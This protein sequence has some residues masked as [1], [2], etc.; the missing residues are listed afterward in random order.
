M[1]VAGAAQSCV[2]VLSLCAYVPQ[3]RKL[4]KTR[5]SGS[6]SLISWAI[7]TGS[8]SIAVFYSSILLK[9]TGRGLPLVVTTSVGLGCVLLTMAMIWRFRDRPT[10]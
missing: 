6:I 1:K 10:R 4:L 3:W 9:V 2:P 8:Y 5:S 7:W